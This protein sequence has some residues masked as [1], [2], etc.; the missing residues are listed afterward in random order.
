MDEEE[1]L[2]QCVEKDFEALTDEDIKDILL[3]GCPGWR[4]IYE[5]NPNLPSSFLKEW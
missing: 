5:E 4:K 3:N 2:R 1:L